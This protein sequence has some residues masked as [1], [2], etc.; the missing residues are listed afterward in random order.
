MKS[1]AGQYSI[2]TSATFFL[3]PVAA[4]GAVVGSFLNVVIYR[5][6]LGLSIFSPKW[7][8]CPNCRETIRPTDNVPIFGW[9]RLKGRC[10]Y[11]TA[12][13]AF[14]Y[15]VIECLTTLAFVAIWD[16]LFTAKL[17]PGVISLAADWP[18][19]LAYLALFAGLLASA[20]MDIESYT[21]DIRISVVV[22]VVAVL[23]HGIRGIPAAA[24]ATPVE[25]PLGL[26][27]P[28]LCVVAAAMGLAWLIG[29]A[30]STARH[31]DKFEPDATAAISGGSSAP[32]VGESSE[33]AA[34]QTVSSAPAI[35]F[36]PIPII[37]LTLVI[38]V[39]LA[40]QRLAPAA[41]AH[42]AMSAGM[43]RGLI[44][45]GVFMCVLILASWIHRPADA[46]IVHEIE[47]A[48]H[49]ARSVAIRELATFAPAI[50]VGLGVYYLSR[51]SSPLNIQ[52]DW[53]D[54]RKTYLTS[55]PWV[56]F[57]AGGLHAVAG[58]VFGSALGWTVRI[59]GTLAFG[60]EAF[61]TGD[62]Y[63]MG[64][65]GAAAG[66]PNLV[67]G[68]FLSALL[69]L[70]GVVATLFHKSSRAIPFGP[71]LALGSFVALLLEGSL[72]EFFKPATAL[73]WSLISGSPSWQFGG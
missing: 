70:V 56:S 43:L 30:I 14:I 21:I 50:L 2:L 4:L 27:P 51:R 7:S 29:W 65:I 12:P 61:G 63:L 15:P 41:P 72:L 17:V 71:W 38:I 34:P 45:F 73:L 55:W 20:A 60:K 8:F 18:V 6:P 58:M 64:A 42:L 28:G 54:V 46:E 23:G 48:R 59:L 37:F 49:T 53:S 24:L 32:Q 39:L 36:Q 10:R 47:S 3:I 40:W 35:R 26:L 44:A 9:L 66:V 1:E 52:S 13:I 22:M 31:R 68:F 33:S 19:A 25:H 67:F 57:A 11:C 62:I 16:I 5:L 69:A